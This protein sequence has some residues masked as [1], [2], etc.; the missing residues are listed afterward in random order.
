MAMA[1]PSQTVGP[2]FARDLV[3]KD[4]GNVLLGGRGERVTLTGRVLD[5][6]GAPVSDALF[7]T[8][9]A[10]ADGK[11]PAPGEGARPYGYARVSTGPDGGYRIET[12]MPAAYTDP[13]GQTY[14]PQLHVMIFARGLLKAVCTRVFLADPGTIKDDPLARAIGNPDRLRTLVA[15]RDPKDPKLYRWDVRLQGEGETVFIEL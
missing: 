15:A 11:V 1:T 7:E 10:D 4:G 6:A 3:W 8:W 5:G 14:A 9:Q 12:A 13:G 2:F